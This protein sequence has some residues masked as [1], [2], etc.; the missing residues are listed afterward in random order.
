MTPIQ[1]AGTFLQQVELVSSIHSS[2]GKYLQKAN[3]SD[4]VTLLM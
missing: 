1:D 2:V 4:T 3:A